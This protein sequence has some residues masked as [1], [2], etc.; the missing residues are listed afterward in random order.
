MEVLKEKTTGLCSECYKVVDAQVIAEEGRAVILKTCPHHGITKGVIETD[1]DFYK[2]I[3]HVKRHPDPKP[4]PFRTLMINITHACNLKCNLCYLPDRDTT[5]DFTLEEIKESISAYPGYVISLSGGEPTMRADLLEIIR[6]AKSEQK[7]CCLVTNGIKLSDIDFV[8]KLKEAGLVVINYSC[9]GLKKEAF[10]EIENADLLDIKL[11]GLENLKK[12]GGMF[13]Q[14]SYTMAKG[15]NDDQLGPLRD[16]ALS[17]VDFIYQIRARVAT[18]VGR[19]LGEKD[20]YLSDFIKQLA[21]VTNIP[22]EYYMYYWTKENWFP[23]T[24]LFEVDFFAFLED[25]YISKKLG[26]KG[27]DR[28]SRIEYL[29]KYMPEKTATSIVDFKEA[30]EGMPR[31]A[32]PNFLFFLFSWPDKNTMDYEEVKGLDLDILL[33]DRTVASYWDGIIRNEKFGIL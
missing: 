9:N 18:G 21:E 28:S 31:T 5:R 33:R 29:S 25:P 3:V 19:R 15:I 17:N 11:K 20:I 4:F 12:V 16:Y 22:Y 13:T 10:T 7:I 30:P 8:R 27:T 26:S 6:H 23:N 32:R 24:Y 14:L 1:L 2:R